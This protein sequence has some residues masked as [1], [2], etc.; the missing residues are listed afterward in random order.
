MA[1]KKEQ[2]TRRLIIF[3]I[4]EMRSGKYKNARTL[5]AESVLAAELGIS[6]VTLREAL[7][8]LEYEGWIARKHG[9][10]TIINRNVV[11]EQRRLDTT[12]GLMTMIRVNGKTPRR[13]TLSIEKVPADVFMADTLGIRTGD[14]LI[15]F[16]LK[17]YADEQPS[18]YCV[19]YVPCA[20]LGNVTITE[21][22]YAGDFFDFARKHRLSDALD[23]YASKLHLSPIT[24]EIADIMGVPKTCVGIR[25]EEIGYDVYTK[26][27]S[28]TEQFYL[29]TDMT[30][31]IIRKVF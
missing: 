26:P 28:Y 11:D 25:M 30:H 7:I 31:V 29:D 20:V 6:R 10:G 14:M 16:V 23:T 18:V 22:D 19:D 15:K 4:E 2:T 3:L 24:P 17:F 13:E 21:E 9:I 5:P 8:I 27:I 1:D 12:Q